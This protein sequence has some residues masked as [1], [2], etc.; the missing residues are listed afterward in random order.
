M[1][2]SS[3]DW[4][5]INLAKQGLLNKDPSD[6]AIANEIKLRHSKRVKDQRLATAILSIVIGY[7][8]L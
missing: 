7:T 5:G 8:N 1:Q 6:F 4:S 3:V 2:V